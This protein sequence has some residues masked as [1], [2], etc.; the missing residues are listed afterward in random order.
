[1]LYL[2]EAS[3]NTKASHVAHA[4]SSLNQILKTQF[5]IEREISPITG[6]EWLF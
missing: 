3:I 6:G 5:K 2:R 1:M 4:G